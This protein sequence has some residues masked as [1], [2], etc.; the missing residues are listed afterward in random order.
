MLTTVVE[1][2]IAGIHTE[3]NVTGMQVKLVSDEGRLVRR[4]IEQTM[5]NHTSM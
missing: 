3:V 1:L 4:G 2:T 5:L